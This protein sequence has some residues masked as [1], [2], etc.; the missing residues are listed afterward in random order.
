MPRRPSSPLPQS[1]VSCTPALD[2]HTRR[3]A[4]QSKA[5]TDL[6]TSRQE[7]LRKLPQASFSQQFRCLL[8]VFCPGASSGPD[9][10]RA[11]RRAAFILLLAPPLLSH[12]KGG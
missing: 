10:R 1:P 9:S 5:R 2:A 8:R 11:R 12:A 4:E 7:L 6:P 3:G